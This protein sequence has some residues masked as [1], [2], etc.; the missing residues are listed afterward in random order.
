MRR[1]P[2]QPVRSHLC[3]GR[4]ACL[5]LP[6]TLVGS[7]A[8]GAAACPEAAL[9]D[10]CAWNGGTIGCALLS[11]LGDST[12]IGSYTMYVYIETFIKIGNNPPYTSTQRFDSSS[13]TFKLPAIMDVKATSA[14]LSG[15]G[16]IKLEEGKTVTKDIILK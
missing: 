14:G 5:L 6:R 13:Y 4:Y 3:L 9:V 1:P 11:G 16:I 2:W 10:T 15:L 7:D 8:R 12:M